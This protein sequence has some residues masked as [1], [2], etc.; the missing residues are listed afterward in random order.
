MR[1]STENWPHL[2]NGERYGLGYYKSLILRHIIISNRM[3]NDDIQREVRNLF[4]RTNMML[5]RRF[6][7]CFTR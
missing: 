3:D 5:L 7:K 2:G 6:I 4:M 1:F